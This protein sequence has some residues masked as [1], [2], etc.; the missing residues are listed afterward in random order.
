MKYEREAA[1][2]TTMRDTCAIVLSSKELC[3]N[4]LLRP[5]SNLPENGG[6]SDKLEQ[7]ASDSNLLWLHSNSQ[8]L[9]NALSQLRGVPTTSMEVLQLGHY[10]LAGCRGAI[11]MCHCYTCRAV[12][13]DGF[14]C[15]VRNMACWKLPHLQLFGGF[16]KWGVPLNHPC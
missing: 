9:A 15:I 11:P 3:S 4:E 1:P 2:S 12:C 16:L 14:P 6:T 5:T 10:C 7:L 8:R 13:N